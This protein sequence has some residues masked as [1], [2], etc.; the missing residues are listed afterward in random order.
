VFQLATN[1]TIPFVI[2]LLLEYVLI[3]KPPCVYTEDPNAGDIRVAVPKSVSA[4]GDFGRYLVISETLQ[5]ADCC[6]WLA[7]YDF[8]LVL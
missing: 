4:K 3:F 6:I 1:K 2:R 7:R 5:H 8:L